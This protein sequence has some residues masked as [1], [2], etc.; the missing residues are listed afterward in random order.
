MYKKINLKF[1]TI[2]IYKK[3]FE[4]VVWEMLAIVC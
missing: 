2:F 4:N 3:L 1:K